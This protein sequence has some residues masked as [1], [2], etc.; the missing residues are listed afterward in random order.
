M[1]YT[2]SKNDSSLFSKMSSSL[3]LLLAVYVDD[4]LL[5]G[6]DDYEISALKNF[7]DA[8]F[9][10]KDLGCVHYFLCLEVPKVPLR[11][12]VNQHKYTQD[13][14]SEF[15]CADAKPALTPLD[16]HLKLSVDSGDPML[17]LPCIEDLL[18]S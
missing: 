11:Y 10:I 1:G 7:L 16:P 17:I 14:L 2:A 8:Q 5:E 6:D 12:V 3:S 15:H 13:L 4:I 18:G 9:K